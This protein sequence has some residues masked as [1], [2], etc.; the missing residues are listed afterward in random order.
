MMLSIRTWLVSTDT[1]KDLL[2]ATRLGLL[3]FYDILTVRRHLRRNEGG[4]LLPGVH[5]GPHDRAGHLG[6]PG[7]GQPPHCH[8]R[9]GHQSGRDTLL[10]GSV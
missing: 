8:H 1:N 6:Q 2:Q 5:H 10:I 7:H 9:I 4:S 3:I